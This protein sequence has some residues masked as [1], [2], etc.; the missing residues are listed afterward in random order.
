MSQEDQYYH[1]MWETVMTHLNK[2]E[3]LLEKG[4]EELGHARASVVYRK[5]SDPI[6]GKR[7]S[8]GMAAVTDALV[9]IRRNLAL[10]L[11]EHDQIEERG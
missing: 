10:A 6:M 8:V 11:H 9:I 2:A 3:V 5:L 7:L 4:K 1:D